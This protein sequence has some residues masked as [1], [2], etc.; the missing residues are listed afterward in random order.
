M[1]NQTMVYKYNGIES[2]DVIFNMTS[3]DSA[4]RTDSSLRVNK[5]AYKQ[6]SCLVKSRQ[7]LYLFACSFIKAYCL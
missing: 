6:Q 4:T 1:T 3:K 5:F 2:F 7:K